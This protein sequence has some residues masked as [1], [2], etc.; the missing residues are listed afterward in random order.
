VYNLNTGRRQPDGSVLTDP[1]RLRPGWV[2]TLPWD[3][4]GAGVQYGELPATPPRTAVSPGSTGGVR[5]NPDQAGGPAGSPAPGQATGGRTCDGKATAST[6]KSDWA[7]LRMA[8]GQA[9][10]STRGHG[11]MVAVVDSGVDSSLPQLSG[12][13]SAGVDITSGKGRGDLDCIGSG[14]AMAGIIAGRGDPPGGGLTGIAPDATI[15]PIRVV[16]TGKAAEPEDE[17]DAIKVAVGAGASVIALGSYVDLREPAVASAVSA[18]L[19]HD[20]LIVAAALTDESTLP[21]PAGDGGRGALVTAGGVGPDNRLAADYQAHAVDVVAPGVDVATLGRTGFGTVTTSGSQ[22]AVAFVAGQAALV[23]AAFPEFSAAQVK[24]RIQVT[25]DKMGAVAPDARY[26]WGMINP[27]S[28]VTRAGAGEVRNPGSNTP[29]TPDTAPALAI[30]IVVLVLL[31]A[32]ALLLLRARRWSRD[33]DEH[34]APLRAD[35]SAASENF[36]HVEVE[37]TDGLCRR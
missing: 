13:V 11:V 22:Y 1:A 7:Q 18:A 30:V 35:E 25:A 8:P 17:A 33:D 6:G 37:P 29:N 4:V 20:V 14:T 28:A 16:N 19:T 10:R 24:H 12:R 27:A 34:P 15:L 31:A 36:L 2:L 23:R 26:G 5:P 32:V 3:A 21:S 9:W